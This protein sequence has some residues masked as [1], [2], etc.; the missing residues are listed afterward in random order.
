LGFDECVI[1]SGRRCGGGIDIGHHCVPSVQGA[2][3]TR[4]TFGPHHHQPSFAQKFSK[5][6]SIIDE[7]SAWIWNAPP[8]TKLSAVGAS[9]F[10]QILLQIPLSEIEIGSS[11]VNFG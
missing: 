5:P 4:C 1:S 7:L 11:S 2:R 8:A 6:K 10:I 3:L 9:K